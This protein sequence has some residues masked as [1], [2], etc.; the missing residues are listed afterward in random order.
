MESILLNDPYNFLTSWPRFLAALP[1]CSACFW[2]K[3]LPGCEG[4][5]TKM[6]GGTKILLF[7]DCLPEKT[8]AFLP[9]K[10]TQSCNPYRKRVRVAPGGELF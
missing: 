5:V 6:T 1:S 4:L 8:A 3:K 7:Y 9:N 2:V 10:L